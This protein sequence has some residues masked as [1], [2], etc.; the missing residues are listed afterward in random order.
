MHS[1]EMVCRGPAIRDLLGDRSKW[2]GCANGLKAGEG[3][4]RKAG[5][6]SARELGSEPG[7]L[8]SSHQQSESLGDDS[9]K[10][11]GPAV[12]RVPC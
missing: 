11:S 8:R 3:S 9:T 1:T 5:T 6:L 7:G 10:T 12:R 4:H 2:S